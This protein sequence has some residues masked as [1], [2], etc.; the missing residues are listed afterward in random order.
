MKLKIGSTWRVRKDHNDIPPG[1]CIILRN[2]NEIEYKYIPDVETDDNPKRIYKV[3][4]EEY[5]FY[6]YDFV[7]PRILNLDLKIKKIKENL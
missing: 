1:F 2:E 6:I 7:N 3:S 4:N 5:F